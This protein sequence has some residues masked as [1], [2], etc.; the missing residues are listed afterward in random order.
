MRHALHHLRPSVR[1]LLV[2]V[3]AVVVVAA[4]ACGSL[5]SVPNPFAASATP[6]PTLAIPA[7][8]TP[9]PPPAPTPVPEV[10]PAPFDPYWVRNH[11][12]TELWSGASVGPGTI[13]FG[14]TSGQF[15]SFLVVLP[16]EGDRLYVL[17]PYSQ[18]YLWIDA[19]DVG[20][21]GPPEQRPDP[22]P[23]DVN[24]T[25]DIYTE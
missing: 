8:L 7:Q 20:P 12:I 23:T 9:T 16:P 1:A 4:S 6:R 13:S 17:N 5:P 14:A 21:A 18:D 24:C 22:R 3:P 15:C 19:A 25:Q 11:R 10:A 2:A